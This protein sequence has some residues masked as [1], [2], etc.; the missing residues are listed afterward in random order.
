MCYIEAFDILHPACNYNSSISGGIPLT[1]GSTTD[2][3]KSLGH[4]LNFIQSWI[5]SFEANYS[6]QKHIYKEKISE[7]F[8]KI[9][10]NIPEPKPN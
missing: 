6:Q 8:K 2:V 9:P 7:T 5:Q 10:V 3:L 1:D 4:T